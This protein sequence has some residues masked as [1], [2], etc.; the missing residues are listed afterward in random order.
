VEAAAA[1][2]RERLG[3]G[4]EVQDP[5]PASEVELRKPRLKRPAAFGDLFTEGAHA[6]L[7]HVE[8]G[9][10]AALEFQVTKVIENDA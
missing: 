9:C 8:H 4:G 7:T 10:D 5:V 6:R 1:A 2:I 3:F